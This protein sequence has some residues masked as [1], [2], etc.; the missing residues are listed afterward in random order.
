[1]SI[2]IGKSNKKNSSRS[3]K[4]VVGDTVAMLVWY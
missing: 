4:Y 1:M 3:N 2:Y